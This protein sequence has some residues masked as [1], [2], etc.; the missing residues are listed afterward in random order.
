MLQRLACLILVLFVC[1]TGCQRSAPTS[2]PV[3]APEASAGSEDSIVFIS[4]TSD[5]E[6][7]PQAVDMAMKLA[8]FSLDEDR[9]VAM[10]FNVKG[11]KL[12]T[13]AFSDE[14]AFQEN[15]PIKTQLANLI[16]RGAEVHV[17]PICMKAHGVEES[18]I[19]AGAQVTTRPK[20]FAN[21][22]A[23]TSVFTY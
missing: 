1:V 22:G 8:G 7:N 9:R 3:N 15:D 23:D 6:Q 2:T 14:F 18:D 13:N 21:I 5:A 4:V 19:V 17:C 12:P 16:E 11:V 20:L 10:F